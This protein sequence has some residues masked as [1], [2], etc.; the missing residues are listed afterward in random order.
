LLA[1]SIELTAIRQ[2]IVP[3]TEQG[4]AAE[5]LARGMKVEDGTVRT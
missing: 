3:E 2:K 5:N 4:K 1:S